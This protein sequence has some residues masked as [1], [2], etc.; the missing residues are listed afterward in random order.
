[1]G[2]STCKQAPK[3]ILLSD[4]NDSVLPDQRILHQASCAAHLSF[5]PPFFIAYRTRRVFLTLEELTVT[6]PRRNQRPH[7]LY[8]NLMLS[9]LRPSPDPN[10]S[11][12]CSCYS[13]SVSAWASS[14]TF[15]TG[16]CAPLYIT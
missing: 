15:N 5:I 2:I 8:N 10:S 9:F 4:G 1:M 16:P 14:T 6:P 7:R 3:S 13:P 11:C 12:S